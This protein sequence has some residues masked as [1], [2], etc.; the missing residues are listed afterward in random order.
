M[1]PSNDTLQFIIRA[2]VLTFCVCLAGTLAALIGVAVFRDGASAAQILQ[3]L[4][5]IVWS[6]IAGL[7]GVIGLHMIRPS[8]VV[9]SANAP[10]APATPPA[11]VVAPIAPAAPAAGA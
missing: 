4:V 1:T 7:G 11:A 3:S 9:A 6:L 8:A 5:E 2:V 10:D